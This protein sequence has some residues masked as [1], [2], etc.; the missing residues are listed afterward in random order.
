MRLNELSD[1][2]GATHRK[3]R[4][5]RGIGSGK[6]KTGGRGIKGQKSRSGVTIGGFEGGQMPIYM[7]LP[8][9]GFNAPNRKTYQELSIAN[10]NRAIESGKIDGKTDLDAVALVEAGVIRRAKD[11]VRLIGTGVV[12]KAVNLHVSGA[13][14]GAIASV[15]AAKGSVNVLSQETL[16]RGKG[17]K[18]GRSG[19]V[20]KA[21]KNVAKA[22]SAPLGKAHKTEKQEASPKKI[23][24]K[25]NRKLVESIMNEL[26]SSDIREAKINSITNLFFSVVEVSQ[27]DFSGDF[28]LKIPNLDEK[29]LS[30]F[31]ERIE[32]SDLSYQNAE[33]AGQAISCIVPYL[34]G[35]PKTHVK[36]ALLLLRYAAIFDQFNSQTSSRLGAIEQLHDLLVEY[37]VP[38]I[39]TTD[40]KNIS[41]GKINYVVSF[42]LSEFF[43]HVDKCPLSESGLKAAFHFIINRGETSFTEELFFDQTTFSHSGEVLVPSGATTAFLRI[44]GISEILRLK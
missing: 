19:I 38:A 11:G 16:Y 14:N 34:Y 35:F 18:Q 33:I 41:D 13:T 8:K 27:L 5:G 29:S 31:S 42:T 25:I 10:L 15:E 28:L 44:N 26:L 24:E 37:Q 2:D 43:D 7:R 4:I 22:N 1:N 12:S 39:I 20:S 3:K 17:E 30:K 6:G 21:Y 9:R 23:V 32:K 40:V 36:K